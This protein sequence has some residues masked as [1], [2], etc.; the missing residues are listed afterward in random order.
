[1]IKTEAA[2]RRNAQRAIT[3]QIAAALAVKRLKWKDVAW[4][5]GK[6]NATVTARKNDNNW[7]LSEL[8]T[9]SRNLNISFRIG[10]ADA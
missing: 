3:D 7:E 8:V 5:I 1:M 10:D 2:K 6:S 9:L 4:M